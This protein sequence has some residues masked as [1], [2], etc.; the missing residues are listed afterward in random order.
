MAWKGIFG[1]D[2]I[3]DQFRFA[4]ERDRMGSSFLFVGPTGIG[5]YTFAVKLAQSILCETQP[6][7]AM[8]PCEQCSACVQVSAMTHPD[9]LTIA[10]PSDRSYIPLELFIG[11]REHRMRG[12]LCHDIALKPFRGGRKVALIDDADH[13]NVEGANCLL[14]TLEEP[15]PRS[16]IILVGTSPAKQLPT[17]RSRCQIVRFQPLPTDI[18][19]K[20]ILAGGKIIDPDEA[21]QIARCGNGSLQKSMEMTVPD[22]RVFQ[23]MFVKQLSEPALDSIR[24]ANSVTTFVED[25]GKNA[26]DRRIRIRQAV[27]FAIDFYQHVLHSVSDSPAP[28]DYLSGQFAEQVCSDWL[29]VEQVAKCLDRCVKAIEDLDRNANQT[30]LIECW[31]DDLAR[32]YC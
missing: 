28:G 20:L 24:M 14:K 30:T 3:V 19:A 15:P 5:K 4:L 23:E 17:I 12:G 9:L 7:E 29:D 21:E 26:A 31:L 18:V 13:I 25:A 11:D 16:V 8:A 6:D 10:K 27:T 22:L 2:N 32:L 1:H